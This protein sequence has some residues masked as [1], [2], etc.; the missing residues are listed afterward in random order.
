MRIT[1]HQQ[2]TAEQVDL[3]SR[4]ISGVACTFGQVGHTSAGPTIV[5]ADAITVP[6]RV[7]ML[8]GHDD[9]RPIGR[10]VAHDTDESR[11][12]ARFRV[13]GTGAGDSALLEAGEGIRD[14]LSVGLDVQQHETDADGNLVVTA[15]VLREVSLVTFPAFADA[16]V[17]DVAA[18]EETPEETPEISDAPA[19]DDT[20]K[21][22]NPVDDSTDTTAVEVPTVDAAARI[23]TR[24]QDPFPYR[25]G[26]Q[27]SYFRDLVNARHDVQAAQRV[28]AAQMMLEAAQKQADV[29]EVIPPGYRPDLYVGQEGIPTPIANAMTQMS[30]SDATP[31]KIP[32]FA[33]STSLVAVHVEGVNPTD[34]TV[35]FD[36]LTVTP[37]AISGKYTASREMLDAANPNLDAIIMRAMAEDYAQHIEEFAALAI[38]GAPA[39]T[40]AATGKV[41]AAATTNMGA[42][43]AARMYAADRFLVGKSYWQKLAADT[44]GGGRPLNPY[45]AP[46]NASGTIGAAVASVSVNG[47]PAVLAS[48]LSDKMA[49][50]MRS[51]D[52]I[53]FRSA[54]LAWRWEEQAGPANIVFA[55]FGY[56]AAVETHAN[57]SLQF[58]DGTT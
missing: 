23:P 7:V 52:H 44:D 36:E 33:S 37:A 11:L 26:V 2:V 38:A 50:L 24:V 1:A 35:D 45:L 49:V 39:G 20:E 25:E 31:F 51:A 22:G 41:T 56:V 19:P 29:A 9:D 5:K 43:V 21:E 6:E 48:H 58:T 57:G 10:M 14:G 28:G 47:L 46:S 30:I 13:V 12:V 55:Q 32:R 4:T 15:A 34:G 17:T 27:A 54:R 40:N 8:V 3:D 53:L 42:F 16:R 18:S